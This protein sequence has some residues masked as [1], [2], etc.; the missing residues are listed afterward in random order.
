[1]PLKSIISSWQISIWGNSWTRLVEYDVYNATEKSCFLY[2]LYGRDSVTEWHGI[3]WKFIVQVQYSQE[4]SFQSGR[5][6]YVDYKTL[7]DKVLSKVEE[8]SAL[9][10]LS[11]PEIVE[12][13]KNK[14]A[15][16][17]FYL[18]VLSNYNKFE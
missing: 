14:G 6:D 12:I 8:A 3:L 5:I 1:M 15:A 16:I 9:Q 11:L 18:G 10:D 4:V 17:L 7:Y 2:C 13:L